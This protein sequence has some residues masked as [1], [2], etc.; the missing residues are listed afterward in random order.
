[1]NSSVG[2]VPDN[3]VW[4]S[5][6]KLVFLADP[7]LEGEKTTKGAETQPTDQSPND[8][9]CSPKQEKRSDWCSMNS[10]K[11]ETN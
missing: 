8:N 9:E 3:R 6:D 5:L 1:V 10:S 7:D 2:W 11:K 4:S